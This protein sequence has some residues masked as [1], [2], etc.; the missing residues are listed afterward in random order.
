MTTDG[1]LAIAGIPIIKATWVTANTALIADWS[2][3]QV[4]TVDSLRVEF[5]EQDSDNVQRNLITVRV[6]AR[7]VLVTGQPYAFVNA[8]SGLGTGA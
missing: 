8:T 3:S 4:A 2:Q 6:E 1:N 7:V 5:F